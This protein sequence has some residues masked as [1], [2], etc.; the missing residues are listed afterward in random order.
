MAMPEKSR[1]GV[2]GKMVW[3]KPPLAFRR[4][5]GWIA[6]A[7]ILTTTWSWSALGMGMFWTLIEGVSDG[8]ERWSLIACMVETLADG[9]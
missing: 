1:P 7:W 3:S 8:E 6:A 9:D 4:S 2:R 5:E